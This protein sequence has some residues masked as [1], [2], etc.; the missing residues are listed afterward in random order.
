MASGFKEANVKKFIEKLDWDSSFFGI[1]VGKCVLKGPFSEVQTDL[2]K[3]DFDLVYIFSSAT[4]VGLE[5]LFHSE[6]IRYIKN[7]SKENAEPNDRIQIAPNNSL[8]IKKMVSRAGSFSR[9]NLDLK[10]P[11]DTTE[12][13]YSVWL[14]KCFLDNDKECLVY[15]KGTELLGVICIQFGEVGDILLL[16]VS[17]KHL[18]KGIGTQL[19]NEA[20]RRFYSK[21]IEKMR[22]Q[23]QVLNTQATRFYTHLGFKTDEQ[24]HIY[25]WRKPTS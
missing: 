22:V 1:E 21:R 15:T 19:M 3:G 7:T 16:A 14:Q 6:R 13:L 12:K 10:F 25:H 8:R 18:S 11:P 2:N 9:F 5:Q 17:P 23:T 24:W 20:N 4:V